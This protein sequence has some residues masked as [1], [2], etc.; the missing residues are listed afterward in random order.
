[1]CINGETKIIYKWNRFGNG[2]SREPRFL[3]PDAHCMVYL[4]T[5]W[6]ILMVNDR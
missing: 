6:S 2:L 1:M 4:P 5:I 3:I